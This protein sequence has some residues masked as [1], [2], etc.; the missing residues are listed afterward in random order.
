MKK[1]SFQKI[2]C[3]VS[4]LFILSC[5]IFYGTRFIKLFIANEKEK[6]IEKDSL[7]KIIKEN[8][9]DNKNFQ[10]I[11]EHL[12]FINDTKENNQNG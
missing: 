1:L 6:R 2:F 5:C 3:F 12:Y 4:F 7:V 11:D 9:E 10:N 8:N